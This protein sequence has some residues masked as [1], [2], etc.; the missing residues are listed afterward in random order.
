MVKFWKT[1]LGILILAGGI[2]FC[3]SAVALI[4]PPTQKPPT[5]LPVFKAKDN[6]F[7]DGPNSYKL[8]RVNMPDGTWHV[9][10]ILKR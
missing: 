6:G 5:D 8:V 7:S 3:L 10:A 1:L 9:V 4:G 2:V